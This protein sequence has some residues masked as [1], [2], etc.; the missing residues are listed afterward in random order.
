MEITIGGESEEDLPGQDF[1]IHKMLKIQSLTQT[2]EGLIIRHS[3]NAGY[4]DEDILIA[5]AGTPVK[6]FD[7]MCRVA[8]DWKPDDEVELTLL[9]GGKEIKMKVRLGGKDEEALPDQKQLIHEMLRISSLTVTNEGLIIRNSASGGYQDE[10][11]LIAMNGIPVKTFDDMRR[12]AKGWKPGDKVE[13]TI[14]T[15][16]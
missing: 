2:N 10:D 3:E 8:K 1:L 4:Q 7:D 16:L 15:F 13:L 14:Q 6:T 12:A 9:R 5:M 11:N